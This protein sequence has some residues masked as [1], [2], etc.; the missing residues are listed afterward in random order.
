MRHPSWTL[1]LLA[2]RTAADRRAL[3]DLIAD[4]LRRVGFE[5]PPVRRLALAAVDHFDGNGGRLLLGGGDAAT[6]IA[7]VRALVQFLDLPY[8]EIDAGGL[9]ETNWM[10]ADLPWH[11]ARLHARLAQIFPPVSVAPLAERAVVHLHHLERLRLPGSYGANAT[12]TA[13]YRSGKQTSILPLLEGTPIP[14]DLGSGKGFTWDGSR[15]LIVVS[16]TF[17]GLPPRPHTE[18]LAEWGLLPEVA[19]AL[20]T[21]ITLRIQPPS[22]EAVVRAIHDGIRAVQARFVSFGLR[23]E[24]APQVVRHVAEAV[25]SGRHPGGADAAIRWIADAAE[26]TLTRLLEEAAPAFTTHVLAVDDLSL[27]PAPRGVWRD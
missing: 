22:A 26:V 24:V 17:A 19:G 7:L 15:A 12:T 18:D 13:E 27:P 14:V 3:Y 9:A 21:F 8:A 4:G 2:P 25:T 23:L 11:M 10:G 5:G 1:D 16:G 6:G 20:S